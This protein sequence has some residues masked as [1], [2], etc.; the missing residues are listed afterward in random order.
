[1]NDAASQII[2]SLKE[3][4][5]ALVELLAQMQCLTQTLK[6]VT[7]RLE[8]VEACLNRRKLGM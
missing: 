7:F 6:D 5:A 3:M 2:A 8:D 4:Q 1:M